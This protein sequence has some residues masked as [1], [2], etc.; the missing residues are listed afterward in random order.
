MRNLGQ[1]QQEIAALEE[2]V[3]DVAVELR[4]IYEVYLNSLS[5]AARQHLIVASYQ[6]CTQIYPESFLTLTLKQREQ[7]QS[8][9]R[10]LGDQLLPQLIDYLDIEIEAPL[11]LNILEQ[12]LGLPE[13]IELQSSLEL[14]MSEQSLPED[15]D[16]NADEESI[17]PAT[18]PLTLKDPENLVYWYKQIEQ[19][20][21]ETLENASKEVNSLLHRDQVLPSQLPASIIDVAMETEETGASVSGSPSLLNLLIEAEGESESAIA[22]VTAIRLRRSEIEFAD[23]TLSGQRQQ[24]RRVF[25]KISQIRQQYRQKKRDCAVAEAEAAWRTSW[26]DR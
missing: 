14:E 3:A 15:K 13:E 6:I 12:M 22:K 18:E 7:L 25:E 19:G 17:E 26:F 4:H 2:T 21:D 16:V 8:E 11:E 1:I 20:I 9:I 24:I 23:P 5:S 10:H